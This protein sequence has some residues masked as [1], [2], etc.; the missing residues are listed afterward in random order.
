MDKE[1]LITALRNHPLLRRLSDHQLERFAEVGD[2]ESYDP[3]EIIVS[4]GSLGDSIFLILAGQTQVRKAGTSERP[5]AILGPGDFFGEMTLVEPAT[6]C[7][8]VI[9]VEPVE[10]FRLP[11][12]AVHL[13]AI[14]DPKGMNSVLVAIIRVQSERIRRMNETLASVGHLSDWLAGSLV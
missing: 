3:E 5:L 9:C 10:A 13:L 4:E 8:S 12:Q 2:L 11:N 6:R 7:A 1:Q 14:E